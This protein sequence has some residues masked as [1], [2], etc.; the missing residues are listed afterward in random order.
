MYYIIQFCYY[1]MGWPLSNV[2]QLKDLRILINQNSIRGAIRRKLLSTIPLRIFCL[3][4]C[5]FLCQMLH[6]TVSVG[7][8]HAN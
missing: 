3:L 2:A 8:V 5:C 4:A 7:T 1:T 6:D